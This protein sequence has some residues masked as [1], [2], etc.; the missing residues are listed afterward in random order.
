MVF[1][2]PPHVGPQR[3]PAGSILVRLM[4]PP[5][6]TAR[7]AIANISFWIVNVLIAQFPHDR[8]VSVH[9]L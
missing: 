5:R 7:I 4:K 8:L 6:M 2:F 3:N 9:R 1:S